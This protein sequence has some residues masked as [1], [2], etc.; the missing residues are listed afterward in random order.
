MKKLS[1]WEVG[2]L[3]VFVWF[4]FPQN[5]SKLTWHLK[6]MYHMQSW[7]DCVFF[8]IIIIIPISYTC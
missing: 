5:L 6:K 1:Q 3:C 2:F 8:L 7:V 4:F